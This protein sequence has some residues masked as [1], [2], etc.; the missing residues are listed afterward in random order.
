MVKGVRGGGNSHQDVL[1]LDA[2]EAHNSPQGSDDNC[3]GLID[4]PAAGG[5][6]DEAGN[7]STAGGELEADGTEDAADLTIPTTDGFLV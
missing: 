5:D 2:K 6:D 4:V 1:E 7:G 3:A